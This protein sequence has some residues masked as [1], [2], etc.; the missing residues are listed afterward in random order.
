M[1]LCHI[2]IFVYTTKEKDKSFSSSCIIY[3]RLLFFPR[4]Y[5]QDQKKNMHEQKTKI[6]YSRSVKER[7]LPLR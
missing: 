6:I 4:V 7:N 1:Y 3:N 5:A 2:Y